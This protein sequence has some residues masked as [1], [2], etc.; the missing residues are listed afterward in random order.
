MKPS[1]D[2]ITFEIVFPLLCF[3]ETD[4]ELWRDDPHEYVRKVSLRSRWPVHGIIP[5]TCAPVGQSTGY[6]LVHVLPLA[7]PRNIRC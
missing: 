2:L 3:G 6:S 4:A 5:R 7:S 1:L